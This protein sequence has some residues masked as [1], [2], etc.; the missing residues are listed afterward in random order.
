M[1]A[2]YFHM[3]LNLPTATKAAQRSLCLDLG[4]VLRDTLQRNQTFMQQHAQYLSKQFIQCLL[5]IHSEIGKRVVV[6]R[7]Q[8]SEPLQSRVNVDLSR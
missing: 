4:A 6:D 8:T 5:V 3:L 7:V 1:L 2:G